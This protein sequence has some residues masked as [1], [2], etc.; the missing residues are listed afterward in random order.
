MTRG[1]YAVEKMSYRRSNCPQANDSGIVSFD[2]H[3]AALCETAARNA[4][5]AKIRADFSKMV[6]V[7]QEFAAE[8]E[9]AL[10]EGSDVNVQR[11][12]LLKDW[13]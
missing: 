8:H 4:P 5:N 6:C 2:R 9:K 10:A 1:S 3:D 12:H 7:W 11:N 13:M